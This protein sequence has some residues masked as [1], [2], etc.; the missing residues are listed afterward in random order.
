M[1]SVSDLLV[2]T[3]FIIRVDISP[4]QLDNKQ[5][6]QIRVERKRRGAVLIL[7]SDTHPGY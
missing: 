2:Q 4:F 7:R 6:K 5:S 3:L 1:N